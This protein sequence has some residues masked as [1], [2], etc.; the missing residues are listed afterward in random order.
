MNPL[1]V[2]STY[3]L[4]FDARGGIN[5]ARNP[6]VDK[7]GAHH[8]SF[9]SNISCILINFQKKEGGW[10]GLLELYIQVRSI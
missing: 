6:A 5:L 7:F 1:F 10:F 2:D 4:G 3:E 9:R 8:W